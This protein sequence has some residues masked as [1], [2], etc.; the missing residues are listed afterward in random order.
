MTFM[1]I[2]RMLLDNATCKQGWASRYRDGG[3]VHVT[4]MVIVRMLLD[5]ATCRQGWG[6]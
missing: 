3:H 4:S 1:V 6:I 5:N 2:V